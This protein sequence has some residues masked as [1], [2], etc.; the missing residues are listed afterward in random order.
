MPSVVMASAPPS[1][2][3]IAM[4]QAKIGRS[5]KKLG[6]GLFLAT[7]RSVD[8][9][10]DAAVPAADSVCAAQSEAR[11]D[12]AHHFLSPAGG[13]AAGLPAAA[14]GCHGT[15]FAGASA[16]TFCT[17]DTTIWSPSSTPSLTI[18][19]SPC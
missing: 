2:I 12:A 17:P 14:S 15:A 5:M 16:L 9:L 19:L 18:Q 7:V 3:R 11:A 10:H 13:A 1:R 8:F 6:M 4:T